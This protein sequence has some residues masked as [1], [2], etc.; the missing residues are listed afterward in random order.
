MT[1]PLILYLD[2]LYH[3]YIGGSL[4]LVEEADRHFTI[5]SPHCH[6]KGEGLE[7]IALI[8]M[9]LV[10]IFKQG[11]IVLKGVHLVKG[12]TWGDDVDKGKAFVIE[13]LPDQVCCQLC[14][15]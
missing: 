7:L 9:D 15:G 1:C 3:F 2:L 8:R 11:F 14:I 10:N 5:I 13:G 6:G 4:F 12:G